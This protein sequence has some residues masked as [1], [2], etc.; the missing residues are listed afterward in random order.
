MVLLFKRKHLK[1]SVLHEKTWKKS[2]TLNKKDT[3]G[4][5]VVWL[6]FSYFPIHIGFLSS[7]QLT[8]SII[9]SGRGGLQTTNQ[10]DF[11]H[12]K[13]PRHPSLNRGLQHMFQ[14]DCFGGAHGAIFLTKMKS[15]SLA[16]SF[17]VYLWY[18]NMMI[19]YNMDIYI[20]TWRY[21]TYVYIY[22]YRHRSIIF[23]PKP[24]LLSW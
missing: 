15:W 17:I 13:L 5:L 11:E 14:R 4:W 3:T 8:K 7:S 21:V 10:L 6:P 19:Y 2:S 12:E 18:D 23:Y 22:I 16:M 9:F 20:Y 24:Y 1:P